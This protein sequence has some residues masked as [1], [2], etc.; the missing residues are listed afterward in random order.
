MKTTTLLSPAL[1]LAITSVV[2]RLPE[3]MSLAVGIDNENESP[4]PYFMVIRLTVAGTLR[5]REHI[6]F[7]SEQQVLEALLAVQQKLGLTAAAK[8]APKRFADL[9]HELANMSMTASSVA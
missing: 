1:R 5:Q 3:C 9:D 2:S 6:T 4:E 8:P 7:S